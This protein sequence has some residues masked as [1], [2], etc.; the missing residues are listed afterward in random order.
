[1]RPGVAVAKVRWG[2]LGVAKIGVTKVIPAMQRGESTVVV[3]I[4]SRQL[5]RAKEAA[6]AL[7]I[8][9]AAGRSRDRSDLHPAAQPPARALDDT[10]G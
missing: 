3:A 8:D 1:M 10:R 6:Q 9:R 7:G 2:V 4:A 5:V